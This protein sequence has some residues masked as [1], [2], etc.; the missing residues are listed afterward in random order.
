MPD[1][2]P[3]EEMLDDRA[4]PA[5]KR[6]TVLRPDGYVSVVGPLELEMEGDTRQCCHCQMHWVVKVGSGKLRGFCRSCMGSVC[7]KRKCMTECVPAEKMLEDM[8][9]GS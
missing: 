1:L 6:V 2:T 3:I 4:A 9:K 5:V 7:G 8:E